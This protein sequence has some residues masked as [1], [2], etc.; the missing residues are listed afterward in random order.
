MRYFVTLLFLFVLNLNTNAAE[1]ITGIISKNIT[2]YKE[3]SPYTFGKIYIP[4]GVTVTVDKGVTINIQFNN[5]YNSGYSDNQLYCEGRLLVNGTAAEPVIINGT[6]KIGYDRQMN[7]DPPKNVQPTSVFNYCTINYINNTSLYTYDAP[8]IMHHC[9]LLGGLYIGMTDSKE[10]IQYSEIDDCEISN[11]G[12]N[13]FSAHGGKLYLHDS[14]LF[15]RNDIQCIEANIKHNTF[16]NKYNK[17]GDHGLLVSC[18]ITNVVN[19]TFEGYAKIALRMYFDK[20]YNYTIT[21]NNFV[22]NNVNLE[23]DLLDI[24]SNNFQENICDAYLISNNSFH[25]FGLCNVLIKDDNTSKNKGKFV[26]RNLANN[27]WGNITEADLKASIIDNEQDFQAIIKFDIEPYKL[28]GDYTKI[29]HPSKMPPPLFTI[30]NQDTS[31][32]DSE[33]FIEYTLEDKV[34]HIPFFKKSDEEI[35]AHLNTLHTYPNNGMFYIKNNENVYMNFY[36][37]PVCYQENTNGKWV[38]QW[39][40]NLFNVNFTNA[41]FPLTIAKTF[42]NVETPY[43]ACAF[44]FGIISNN[45]LQTTFTSFKNGY[46]KGFIIVN[47]A[48][49]DGTSKAFKAIFQVKLTPLKINKG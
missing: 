48:Q 37:T 23:F 25:N 29:I 36:Q 13:N 42:K 39:D 38:A 47:E 4:P 41:K 19:N 11:N 12:S 46:L 15:D 45:N 22:N 34:Y 49:L 1:N 9:K 32:L 10:I 6:L 18:A 20:R 30:A 40:F 44:R 7:Y 24:T 28:K 3:K 8:V 21:D 17:Y 31:R 14:K 33:S 35:K 43:S 27:F 5:T 2:L 16:T 26:I